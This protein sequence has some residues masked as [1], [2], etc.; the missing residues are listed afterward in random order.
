MVIQTDDSLFQLVVRKPRIHC[1]EV[2]G[3]EDCTHPSVGSRV[4]TDDDF[5]DVERGEP[6]RRITLQH[7]ELIDGGECEVDAFES[8]LEELSHRVKRIA[9]FAQRRIEIRGRRLGGH[10]EAGVSRKPVAGELFRNA[11]DEAKAKWRFMQLSRT[12][13]IGKAGDFQAVKAN[14]PLR[15]KRRSQTRNIAG[16]EARSRVSVGEDFGLMRS[17]ILR[18]ANRD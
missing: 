2:S 8:G 9:S 6:E 12:V 16:R 13:E 18:R 7:L 3:I 14:I 4:D 5:I 1:C 11:E 15:D 17:S 10:W